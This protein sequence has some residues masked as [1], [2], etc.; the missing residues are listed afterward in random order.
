[1]FATTREHG[2]DLAAAARAALGEPVT[3]SLTNL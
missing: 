2:D 1:V 3:S